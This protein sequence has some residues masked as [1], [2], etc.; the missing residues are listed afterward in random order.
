MGVHLGSN[1]WTNSIS[2]RLQQSGFK[3]V[4]LLHGERHTH[5]QLLR[6]SWCV[7]IHLDSTIQTGFLA[8]SYV[9]GALHNFGSV[10]E[11]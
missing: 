7:L 6:L 9:K 4:K 2:L 8:A 3:Q 10:K 5:E 1:K 11:P